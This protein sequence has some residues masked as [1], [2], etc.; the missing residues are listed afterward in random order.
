MRPEEFDEAGE[1]IAEDIVADIPTTPA[2]VAAELPE[3][4]E[5]LLEDAHERSDD[6]ET[7]SQELPDQ[8]LDGSPDDPMDYLSVL[9]PDQLLEELE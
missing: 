2:E 8:L 1:E 7:L 5:S 3:N 4:V 6:I 9:L